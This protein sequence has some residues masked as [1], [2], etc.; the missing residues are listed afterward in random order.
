MNIGT[1]ESVS[2]REQ[3]VDDGT[4]RD[5]DGVLIDL[6]G[7]TIVMAM[8]DRESKRRVLEASTTNGIITITG[9]GQFR[10]TIP[11]TTM[12]TINPET[13]DV[14]IVVTISDVPTQLF[15]GTVAILDGVVP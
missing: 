3:W 15:K 6:S 2:N 9:T 14:G 5:A 1:L 7:A 12:R 4:V 10:W 13:Y 8:Q 11:I